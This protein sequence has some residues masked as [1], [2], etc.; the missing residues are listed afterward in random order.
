MGELQHEGSHFQVRNEACRVSDKSRSKIFIPM[1][2][3]FK[4]DIN[5]CLFAEL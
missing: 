4:F 5:I 2:G 3:M 1:V